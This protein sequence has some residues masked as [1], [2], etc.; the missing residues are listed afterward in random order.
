MFRGGRRAVGALT[1]HID[2]I[3]GCA[4]PGLLERTDQFEETRFGK[5]KLREPTFAHVGIELPQEKE[6]SVSLTQEDSTPESAPI[7]TFPALWAVRQQL[8]SS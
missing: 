4:E 1:S 6:Y 2:Y 7:E 5:L 3:L 8:L